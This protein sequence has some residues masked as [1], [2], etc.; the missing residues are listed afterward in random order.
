MFRIEEYAKQETRVKGGCKLGHFPPGFL[1]G[2][3]LDLE[4]G[5]RI[6]LRNVCL[7]KHYTALYPR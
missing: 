4:D 2:F 1:F 6:F 7:S 5:D 3:F